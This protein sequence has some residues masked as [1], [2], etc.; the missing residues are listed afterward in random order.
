MNTIGIDEF[1][2]LLCDYISKEYSDRG[3]NDKEVSYKYEFIYG[4]ITEFSGLRGYIVV[5]NKILWNFPL[6]LFCG[7]KSDFDDYVL[8]Y[9]FKKV[10]PVDLYVKLLTETFFYKIGLNEQKNFN[11]RR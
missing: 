8:Y 1:C 2:K 6:T 3:F 9:N 4:K 5:N 7:I 10:R 11:S